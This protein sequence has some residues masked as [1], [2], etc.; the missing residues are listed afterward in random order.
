MQAS[1]SPKY[2]WYG[3]DFTG[4]S[5]TLAT[6]AQAGLRAML[7]CGVPT[8][9]Q[10]ARAGTLDAFGVAGAARSMAPEA[11]RAELAAV[12]ALLADSGA[13]VLHYKCCST[14]DSAP[15]VGSIGVA[16]DA[17]R[18]L[19]PSNPV[20]IVGGQPSLGRYCVFG[21]LYAVAQRDGPVYRIDRHPTMSRHPVT[22]MQEADLR[23]HL[24]RQGLRDIELVDVRTAGEGTDRPAGAR[25]ALLYDVLADRDLGPIGRALWTRAQDAP[26]LAVGASSVAQSLIDEWGLPR[27][28]RDGTL[29]AARGPVFLLAGSLSPVTARQ[30]EQ[31]TAYVR[32]PLAPRQL[33]SDRHYVGARAEHIAGLLRAGRHVLA[34][35]TP[36]GAEQSSVAG[37][38]SS[39][40]APASGALL[41]AVLRKFPVSRAGIAGG[42]T[43]SHAVQALDAWGLEWMGQLETGVPV[44]RVHADAPGI[45]GLELM[46]KGGQM[47]GE[48]LFDRLVRGT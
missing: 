6:V 15:H 40:L 21:E 28:V 3:D 42:D 33:A 31:A 34:H 41:H 44:L 37:G 25:P 47:G 10:F 45:D 36:I 29:P 46:L 27:N 13:R 9:Q 16:V 38:V 32:V 5:D 43:S 17:L 2:A 23:V 11:M 18:T 8:P 19:A 4:A 26:V 20:F 22:P 24:A 39:Q 48:A 12:R 1:V 30:I 35:T 7:F 14:F